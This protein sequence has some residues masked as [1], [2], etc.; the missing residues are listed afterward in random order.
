M[1]E[2]LLKPTLDV[3]TG[4]L[5]SPVDGHCP[6]RCIPPSPPW[7]STEQRM[8]GGDKGPRAT[9]PH[10]LLGKERALWEEN[11]HPLIHLALSPEGHWGL[12]P[13]HR[14][15]ALQRADGLLN[16]PTRCEPA[17]GHLSAS[18]PGRDRSVPP[19]LM[20]AW[21]ALTLRVPS[22]CSQPP[23]PPSWLPPWL[24]IIHAHKMNRGTSFLLGVSPRP[25][26]FMR[27][28]AKL[29]HRQGLAS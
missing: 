2:A 1:G 7:G 24:G 22:N 10:T 29:G 12:R 3:W 8:L 6:L 19:R 14:R 20:P 28:F 13:L 23:R 4:F 17:G 25:E 26:E 5:G 27:S 9:S 11:A 16:L 21:M 18:R 15:R